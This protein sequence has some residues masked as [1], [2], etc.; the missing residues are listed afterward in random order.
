M[1]N[2]NLIGNITREI[3]LKFI[4]DKG[5]AVAKFSIAVRRDKENAD[6]INCVAFGKTGELVANFFSKGN[7]IGVT[8][9]LKSGKYQNKEG[10]TVYTTDV[11]VNEITFIDKKKKDDEVNG[12]AKLEDGESP[13]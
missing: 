10:N 13:F 4:G 12:A 11:I 9:K 8:G 3:E 5:L 1:N 6:F 7:S 2:V